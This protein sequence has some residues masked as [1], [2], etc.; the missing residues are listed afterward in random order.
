M[1]I[2][3]QITSSGKSIDVRCFSLGMPLHTTDP[4][5][6]VIDTNEQNVGL[7]RL[8]MGGEQ[9]NDERHVSIHKLMLE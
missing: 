7:N 2:G 9:Q 1:G 3:E 8:Q 6:Q 5:V 4:V